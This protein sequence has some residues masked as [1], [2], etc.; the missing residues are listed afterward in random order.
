MLELTLVW[1]FLFFVTFSFGDLFLGIFDSCAGIKSAQR[2][3]TVRVITGFFVMM[4]LAEYVSL[5]LPLDGRMTLLFGAAAVAAAVAGRRKKEKQTSIKADRADIVVYALCAVWFVLIL[6]SSVNDGFLELYGDSDLYMAQ[7]VRWTAEYGTLKGAGNFNSRIG[8]DSALVCFYA[9]SS[10]NGL[11]GRGVHGACGFLMT[12]FGWYGITAIKDMLKNGLRTSSVFRFVMA[13]YASMTMQLSGAYL[14]DTCTNLAV[15]FF[16]SEWTALAEKKEKKD[17][18]Y[19]LLAVCAVC[20]ASLKLTFAPLVVVALLPGIRLIKAGKKKAAA[21]FLAL[22][23]VCIVPYVLRTVLLT[24]YIAYPMEKIDIL[25]VPW[26]MDKETVV[27]EREM[28]ELYAK[29]PGTD[30]ELI[31]GGIDGW[32]DIWLENQKGSYSYLLIILNLASLAGLAAYHII[33]RKKADREPYL[34]I[35]PAALLAEY[36]YWFLQAPDYRFIFLLMYYLP[37]YFGVCIT[38]LC[39]GALGDKPA[40]KLKL[41]YMAETLVVVLGAGYYFSYHP[42]WIIK[43]DLA[44]VSEL[45]ADKSRR[46]ALLKQPEF[47][48]YEKKGV[49]WEGMTV[50]VPAKG[51][52]AG[53]ADLPCALSAEDLD[54][55]KLLGPGLMDGIGPKAVSTHAK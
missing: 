42:K 5:I 41:L 22:G 52:V 48:G 35:I 36:V 13:G 21:A 26:K 20:C 2:S 27:L 1:A 44:F 29:A 16:I 28:V 47:T 55:L 45:A 23:A 25:N 4:V 14:T 17:E 32:F 15:G 11:F 24:G 38:E 18:T 46:E 31:R 34:M 7:S 51:T 43:D 33:F 12:V 10:F 54:K 19:G 39:H 30:V 53:D 6:V 37:V 9:I 3:V 49:E 50:W 40:S 8:F